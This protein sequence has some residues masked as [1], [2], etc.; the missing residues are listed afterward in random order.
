MTLLP[1]RN[2]L[3]ARSDHTP[4]RRPPSK[5]SSIPIHRAGPVVEWTGALD[6]AEPAEFL[7]VRAEPTQ[8]PQLDSAQ[9]ARI[10]PELPN[11]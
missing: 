5:P 6:P 10:F 8:P 3:C 1:A 2:H 4:P 11:S 9:P 7:I